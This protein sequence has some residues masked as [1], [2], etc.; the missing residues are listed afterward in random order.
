MCPAMYWSPRHLGEY[1]GF[2]FPLKVM[3]WARHLSPLTS[4]GHRSDPCKN[5]FSYNSA[6]RTWFRSTMIDLRVKPSNNGR[7]LARF[8][9]TNFARLNLRI[10]QGLKRNFSP[11][12]TLLGRTF[13]YRTT[14]TPLWNKSTRD[15]HPSASHHDLSGTRSLGIAV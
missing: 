4:C 14:L 9:F 6:D 2:V 1:T 8:F 12:R 7:F 3:A 11:F 15:Y 5:G 13:E 10:L